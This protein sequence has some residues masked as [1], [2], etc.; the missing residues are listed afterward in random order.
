MSDQ[1]EARLTALEDALALPHTANASGGAQ[2]SALLTRCQELEKQLARANYRILHLSKG[3]D[4]LKDKL[5]IQQ[6]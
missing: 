6:K 2:N 5:I 4:E 3:I 1:I